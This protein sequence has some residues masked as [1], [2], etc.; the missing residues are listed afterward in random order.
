MVISQRVSHCIK[1]MC[2]FPT[3]RSLACPVGSF[4]CGELSSLQCF[5]HSTTFTRSISPAS[6]CRSRRG[7]LPPFSWTKISQ[8]VRQQSLHFECAMAAYLEEIPLVVEVDANQVVGMDGESSVLHGPESSNHHGSD[9]I[10]CAGVC[11][12]RAQGN[13]HH[14]KFEQVVYLRREHGKS[15]FCANG[16][17][18]PLM[19]IHLEPD[20]LVSIIP[21]T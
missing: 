12:R 13:P 3:L 21:E 19:Q 16:L 20:V 8:R 5:T 4:C 15:L 9:R 17:Q 2:E 6:S 1:G 7:L 10:P 11:P 14:V 18:P